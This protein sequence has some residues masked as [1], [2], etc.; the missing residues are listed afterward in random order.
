MQK[1]NVEEIMEQIRS[2]IEEKGYKEDMLSFEDLPL[3]KACCNKNSLNSHIDGMRSTFYVEWKRVVNS[4]AKG[5]VKRVIRKFIGFLIAP[6]VEDQ[7]QYNR[8]VLSAFEEVDFILET[9]KK[10]L[11]IQQKVIH[12]LEK[13]ISVLEDKG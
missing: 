13:R 5:I 11:L 7:T 8:N 1:I 3:E 2:E 4:G 10:E 9:Q 12:E 6:I